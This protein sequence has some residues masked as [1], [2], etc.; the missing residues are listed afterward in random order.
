[1][2]EHSAICEDFT[3]TGIN[4]RYVLKPTAQSDL[5]AALTTVVAG[6]ST[7]KCT[8]STIRVS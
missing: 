6:I 8:G 1:M 2:E 3:K 7:A 4:P 5:L